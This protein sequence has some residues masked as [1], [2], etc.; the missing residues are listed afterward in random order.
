MGGWGPSTISRI[1]CRRRFFARFQF[2]DRTRREV[3]RRQAEARP[4]LT[5]VVI[6]TQTSDKD[7]GHSQSS[8]KDQ[9]H[10]LA[11]MVEVGYLVVCVLFWVSKC[12]LLKVAIGERQ[13]QEKVEGEGGG[14]V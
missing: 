4:E 7:Q 1:C 3:R 10:L 2:G 14:K 12:D 6:K 9:G 11:V 5:S 13:G 8:D